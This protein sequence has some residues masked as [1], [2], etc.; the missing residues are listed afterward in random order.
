MDTSFSSFAALV[1]ETLRDPKAVGEQVKALDLPMGARWEAFALVVL[2][3]AIV[4]QFSILAMT[5]ALTAP[6]LLGTP[7]Q[8]VV[9]Q[10]GA[11]LIVVQAIHHVGRAMGGTGDFGGA[12][13]LATW[14]QCVMIFFQVIQVI[15]LVI[16]PPL[17]GIIGVAAMV[18]FFWLL[19]NFIAVLHG[20]TSLGRVFAMIIATAFA[21][22]FVLVFFM[23]M[24][25]LEPPAQG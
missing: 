2:V 9:I 12:L 7:V 15:T 20:F 3:S 5:G 16:L 22:V 6:G 21:L 13:T 8:S 25:G 14:L 10:G 11:L 17:A 19:T 1:R 18:V 24:L 4:G 23:S